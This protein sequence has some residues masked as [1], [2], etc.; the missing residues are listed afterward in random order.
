MSNDFD[1]TFGGIF[2]LLNAAIR[3]LPPPPPQS[4]P[5]V[6]WEDLRSQ[7]DM[8]PKDLMQRLNSVNARLKILEPRSST[9]KD[10][11]AYIESVYET[12]LRLPTDIADLDAQKD[13]IKRVAED[14]QKSSEAVSAALTRV[15]DG[16]A[17]IETAES[18]IRA[19][20]SI[21]DLKNEELIRKSEDVLRGATGVGLASAFENRRSA[22][23]KAGIAWT[24]GLV[25]ALAVL[26][27]IGS[28]RLSALKDV[29]AQGRPS[30]VIWANVLLSLFGIGGPIWFA[31]LSTKQISTNFKLSEDYA[32]KASVSKA[33]E[34][35]RAEAVDI[36]PA[37]RERLFAS[38]LSRIEEAPIRFMEK[39][40]HGGPL[41]E[42]L[43]NDVIRKNL[44]S[45][46]DVVEKILELIPKKTAAT[47]AAI[48]APVAALTAIKS[49]QHSKV[50]GDE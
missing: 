5:K 34:G 39:D 44:E 38:A 15:L 29:M 26:L 45:I 41:Q 27:W 24:F 14:I 12:A 40:I 9:I 37:L 25:A 50:D 30:S 4:P 18:E 10:K 16:Q 36:D 17:R 49:E 35:Y 47:T 3:H 32:F 20:Q 11:I 48:V 28:E 13:E 7:Q 2:Y 22:L 6:D 1:A 8:V 43:S 21:I 42:L 31:W 33:Y 19:N 23:N 46:P